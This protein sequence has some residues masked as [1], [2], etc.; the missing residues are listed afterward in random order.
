VRDNRVS[1]AMPDSSPTKLQ[2]IRARIE[3]HAYHV[4]ATKVADAIVE[5]LL[6]GR[7]VR[8][9]GPAR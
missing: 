3:R 6:A 1:T 7:A 2:E 8:E 4:D 9:I 5:R